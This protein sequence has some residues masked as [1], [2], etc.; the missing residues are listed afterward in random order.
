MAR[1][2]KARL[3][4]WHKGTPFNPWWMELRRLRTAVEDLAPSAHGLLLDVG[5]GDRPYAALF[6][7]HVRRYVG[8]EYPPSCDNLN[9][10]ISARLQRAV[11][12]VD[13]WGDGHALPF[14]A[15]CFDTVMALEVLE[16]LPD[17]DR[18]VSELVRV[19]APGGTLLV[20]VPFCTPLH[21]LPFDFYRFTEAGLVA[22]LERHGLVVERTATRG[23]AADATGAALAQW[24]LRAF[25]ARAVHRDG[26]VSLSRWRAPLVLP[27][28]ALVQSFFALASRWTSDSSSS[29]GYSAVARKPR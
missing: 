25:A 6:A 19:L 14:A 13:V 18:C 20:T 3:F 24:L 2:L 29:L 10:G 22:L 4:A 11:G 26:A 17:P 1:S 5:V 27:V 23:N 12:L 9:P 7:P 16:H 8:I 21:A 28:V 15:G